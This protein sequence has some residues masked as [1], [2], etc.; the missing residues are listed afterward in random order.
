MVVLLC[1]VIKSFPLTVKQTNPG[2][3]RPVTEEKDSSMFCCCCF[4]PTTAR[5]RLSSWVNAK[6]DVW[7]AGG[8]GILLLLATYE[9]KRRR[10]GNVLKYI[11]ISLTYKIEFSL[12]LQSSFRQITLCN[13]ENCLRHY[14]AVSS[15]HEIP[16]ASLTSRRRPVAEVSSMSFQAT[17]PQDL[18]RTNA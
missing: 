15:D 11:N 12:L 18:E 6:M 4:H 8:C 10:N 1:N 16:F 7:F 3:Y 5:H 13:N 2:E 14:V 17:E 9:Y